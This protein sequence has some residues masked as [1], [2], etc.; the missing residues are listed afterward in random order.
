MQKRSFHENKEDANDY[1]IEARR[2]MWS[3][4]IER[5]LL[6]A[7]LSRKMRTM[8]GAD[9]YENK[10]VI[11]GQ[12]NDSY[13]TSAAEHQSSTMLHQQCTHQGLMIIYGVQTSS[14]MN[15][16]WGNA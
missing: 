14:E 9:V 16:G 8:V 10:E 5:L 1:P 7:F 11:R 4:L 12:Q 13:D 15:I 2:Q 6:V 3:L